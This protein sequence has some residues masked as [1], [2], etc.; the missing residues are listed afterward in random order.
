MQDFLLQKGYETD[1]YAQQRQN[2][3][4]IG[5]AT[6]A[7]IEDLRAHE[8]WAMHMRCGVATVW[9][10]PSLDFVTVAQQAET[11]LIRKLRLNIA[12]AILF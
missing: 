6:G 9:K 10:F 1:L 3:L 5:A 7:M 8:R 2:D 4:V 12:T 11:N